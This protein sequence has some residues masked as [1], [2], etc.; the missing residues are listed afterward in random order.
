MVILLV[1]VS[2]L[3][4]SVWSIACVRFVYALFTHCLRIVYALLS[5]KAR[6][7]Y[8]AFTQRL[9]SVYASRSLCYWFLPL[10]F[11]GVFLFKNA[12]YVA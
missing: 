7:F 4:P 12:Q 11:F 5:H 9:R 2:C 8:A 10:F 3:S 6:S 1:I